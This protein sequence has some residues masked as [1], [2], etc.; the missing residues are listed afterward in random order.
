M[1]MSHHVPLTFLLTFHVLLSIFEK[2]I[3]MNVHTTQGR[4]RLMDFDAN[5]WKHVREAS[6]QWWAG[7]LKRP[8]LHITRKDR[9]PGRPESA[10]PW[11]KYTASYD[12]SISAE[13]II[14]RWDYEISRLHFYGDAFPHYWP[15][16]GAGVLAAFL[17]ALLESREETCWFHPPYLREA[18]ELAF[19]FNPENPWFQRVVDILGAAG[20]RWNGAVQVAMTDLGGALDIAASFRPGTQ[21]LLDLYDQP[22]EVKRLTWEAHDAW[23]ESFRTLDAILRPIN[24]GYTAW[25]PIFSSVPYYMLQCDF[26]YMIGPDMFE[27]FVRPELIASCR[28]LA[29]PFYHLDGPGQLIHLDSIL[30][31]PELKGVQWIPGAGAPDIRHWPKVFQK[32]RD[33]GKLI[34]IFGDLEDL[35]IIADQLGSAEGIILISWETEQTESEI[36]AALNKYGAV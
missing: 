24:P 34:Q 33:A 16:F 10:L 7:E 32:I 5:Q 31:I 18:R 13:N 17:G 25:A 36:Q 29:R 26:C 8:L 35:D 22:E 21:L 3:T 15:N 28:K 14:D 6:E 27:E 20:D 23:W 9:D 12:F 30:A 4:N 19:R 2:F 11:K 1:G